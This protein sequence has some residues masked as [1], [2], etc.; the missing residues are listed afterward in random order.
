M[1]LDRAE[2]AAIVRP[3]TYVLAAVLWSFQ[4]LQDTEKLAY[5]AA[6]LDRPVEQLAPD[7][8]ERLAAAAVAHGMEW[9]EA[10]NVI[11]LD[12]AYDVANEYLFGKLDAEYETFVSELRAKNEDRADLQLRS[13]EQHFQRQMRMLEETLEKHRAARRDGLVKATEGRIRA[14]QARV[15]QQRLRIES[16]REVRSN[17]RE[18]AI[19]VIQVK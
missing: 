5:A 19:A 4:G 6:P 8:A 10:R 12:R 1:I 13:L 7:A 17:N 2:V 9:L 11:D 14:L 15:E 16:R 3:G 18:I